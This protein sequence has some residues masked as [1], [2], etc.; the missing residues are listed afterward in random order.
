MTATPIPRTLALILYGDLD[1]SV[2]DELPP[3]RKVIETFLIG[4]SLEDRLNGFIK[5]EIDVG[6]QAYVVCPLIEEQED[7]DNEEEEIKLKNVV[8]VYENYKKIF[9]GYHIEILHGKMKSK[10]K[11]EIMGRFKDGEIDILISTTVIEVGVNVPNA[12]LM[13]IENAER[14]GLAA[15]HQLRGRVGRG[16]EKSYCILKCYKLS[17][18]TKERMDIMT[19]TNDGFKIA[20]KDLE[21][22]GPGEFFGVRQHGIP[23]F[24][25][26]NI[27][28]DKMV[29]EE[30]SKV[31]KEIMIYKTSDP[32]FKP[33]FEKVNQKFSEVV[34]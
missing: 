3:N 18:N 6:R 16:S 14:F 9:P 10:D 7:K 12:T 25:I 23:E 26:A 24:K 4:E 2:I 22:R 19:K 1:I 28:A 21:L 5:K 15:L 20:E 31:A 11:D 29:L 33:L 27:F 8:E 17:K 13:V 30:T 32:E 34:L